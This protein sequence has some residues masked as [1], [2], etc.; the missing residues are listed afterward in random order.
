M[1]DVQPHVVIIGGGFGGLRAAHGLRDAPVRITLLDRR[2][3]HL[4]QPLLYQVATAGLSA[5]N[6]AAPIRQ[7]LRRQKNITVLLGEVRAIHPQARLIDLDNGGDLHYDY[8]IVAVGAVNHWFGQDRWAQHAPG[9]KDL[10]DALEIRR[11]IL[12]A[13]EAAERESDPV[14]QG[15]WL[16][17]IIIG[18]GPTGV[19]LAGSVVDIAFHTV[20]R[21]Y[22]RFDPTRTRVLLLEGADRLLSTYPPDLSVRAADQLRALGVE[23][24]A[25]AKVVDITA[26]GVTLAGG[27]FLAAHTV[28]WAAGVKASPLLESL[29]TPLDRGGRAIV[30]PDL[31]LPHHPEVFVIGDAAAVAQ[32]PGVP[33]VPGVAP[34]ALQMGDHVAEVVQARVRGDRAAPRPFRYI[35]KGSMATIGRKKAVADLGPRLHFGGTFAWLLWMGIH[36]LFLVGFRNRFVVLL[37]W[38]WAYLTYQRSARVISHNLQALPPIH[39]H[40]RYLSGPSPTEGAGTAVGRGDTVGTRVE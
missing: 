4:F 30:Q 2:N 25:G 26:E 10:D 28:L 22:R 13:F 15:A 1:D 36:V 32:G 19:E 33:P 29:G 11:R 3:H 14:A 9:L 7:I 17:F 8:L 37:E 38:A 20:R 27:E 24:R 6:I 12:G 40:P 5:P 23:I 35:D 31:S 39:N 34:A 21:D 18:G 16:T